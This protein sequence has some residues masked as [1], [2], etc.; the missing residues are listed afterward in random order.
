MGR[1]LSQISQSCNGG[2]FVCRIWILNL[3]NYDGLSKRGLSGHH[4]NRE[5]SFDLPLKYVFLPIIVQLVYKFKEITRTLD[6]LLT[7]S[8]LDPQT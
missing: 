5:K 7:A 4:M 1:T 8:E 3:L 6:I 2:W